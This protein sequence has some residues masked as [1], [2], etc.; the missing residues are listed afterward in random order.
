MLCCLNPICHNPPSPDGTK[1]CFN[2]GVSLVTLRNRYRPIKPLGSGGF[3]KTYLA[4][5]TDKLNEKCVIKQLAPQIQG[6]HGLQKAT[7]LFE[8]EA[9]RLQQ[10]GEHLQIPTL[11]A[12]FHENNH[13]YLVQQFIDG[14]NL[15]DEL[16]QNGN[17][18]EQKIRELLLNFLSILKIVHQQKVIHRDI[19][20][21]NIM[22]RHDGNLVLIDFGASKQ[23]LATVISQTK[24]GTMIGS[25]GYVAMEQMQDG[26]AYPASDLYSLGATCFHL[27]SGINPWELWKIQGYGWVANW[28]QSLQQPVSKELTLILDKL[29][30]VDYQERYQSADDVLQDFNLPSSNTNIN[31]PVLKLS[32]FKF[33]VITVNDVGKPINKSQRSVDYFIEDLG[34]GTGIEMIAIPGGTFIMGSTGYKLES[35]SEAPQHQV[36]IQPFFIGKYPVTQKQWAVVATLPKV[37]IDLNINPSRFTGANL[38]VEQ[39][40]WRQANEFCARLSQYSKK[41]TQNQYQKIYR[42]PSE[43]E[44]EYACRAGTTTPFYFGNTLTSSL[45]NYNGNYTYSNSPKGKYRQKTTPVDWFP[46]NAFALY[47]MH[48]NVS[49]W[50]EDTW[51]NNYNLAP[52]DG[53]AWLDN[54]NSTKLVRG[55]SWYDFPQN[56]RSAYRHSDFP[57]NYINDGIGFRVVCDVWREI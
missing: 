43:A 18:S 29:L 14:Q 20:P 34:K 52:T 41:Q 54:T 15:L 19:K 36:T 32:Q 55:G 13:L 57:G 6:T 17:F 23:L 47:N 28:R 51:H 24:K 42:L 35:A 38:P 21:E 33:E 50:C 40:S 9:R 1:F 44:W 10:L 7:E 16:E 37:N 22:R 4:S 45:A 11:L 46:P 5:D 8:Q 25:F 26:E 53:S 30:K 49:E 27:L 56:C 39:I 3:S 12:Y 2:C 48:G 31:P